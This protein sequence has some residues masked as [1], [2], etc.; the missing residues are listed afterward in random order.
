VIEGDIDVALFIG[1]YTPLAELIELFFHYKRIY[2][3]KVFI[4]I[5][6]IKHNRIIRLSII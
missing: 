4:S 1:G 3:I 5:L 6:R 2:N